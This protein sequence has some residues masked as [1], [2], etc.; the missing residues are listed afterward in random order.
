M[1]RLTMWVSWI[2]HSPMI[3][4]YWA[5][6]Q[7]HMVSVPGV[8]LQWFKFVFLILCQSALHTCGFTF[9]CPLG[10]WKGWCA[11]LCVLF[12]ASIKIWEVL[13]LVGCLQVQLPSSRVQ[14]YFYQWWFRYWCNAQTFL[15]SSRPI[16]QTG[17]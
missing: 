6:A 13:R 3:F 1:M 2:A 16:K 15:L 14:V 8:S 4:V 17:F 10:N 12:C 5:G 11:C 9:F 7:F